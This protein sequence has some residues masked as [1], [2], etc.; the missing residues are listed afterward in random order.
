MDDTAGVQLSDVPT[1]FTVAHP[2]PVLD[3]MTA[4]HI[5]F[6]LKSPGDAQFFAPLKAAAE[7][8]PFSEFTIGGGLIECSL[9]EAEVE[10]DDMA[11]AMA[12][13]A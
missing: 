6:F 13:P 1:Y 12:E 3:T 7:H 5:R 10:A 11:A 8:S 2:S 4:S 9:K